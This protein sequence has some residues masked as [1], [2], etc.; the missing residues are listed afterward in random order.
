MDF[1]F[2]VFVEFEYKKLLSFTKVLLVLV[3]LLLVL[4][5]ASLYDYVLSSLRSEQDSYNLSGVHSGV[6]Y[7]LLS[8]NKKFNYFFTVSIPLY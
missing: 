3:L 7:M 8:S 1:G 6:I 2:N 5:S 4:S